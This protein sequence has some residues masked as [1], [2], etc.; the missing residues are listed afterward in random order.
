M[1]LAIM[2]AGMTGAYLYR[3]L[4]QKIPDIDIF[5]LQPRTKCGISPCGWGTSRGFEDLVKT[6]GLDPS[7]YILNRLDHLTMDGIK[8]KAEI[9]TFDKRRLIGD[10]LRGAEV[11]R[12]PPDTGRYDRVIDATGAER[13][14]LPPVPD[15][16]VFTCVQHR[17]RTD[18][19]L[20]NRIS[21]GKIGYA[22]TFPLQPREYHVGCG[23]LLADPRMVLRNLGWES[24]ASSPRDTLCACT[25]R[26]RLTGPHRSGPFISNHKATEV[27]GVGEA[28]GC[29][30]PIAGDGI[31]PG[32]KSALIL[33]DHWDDPAGYE[34]AIL[35][36][37]KWME[38]ERRVMDKLRRNEA[39]ALSDAWA[40]R[41]NSKRMGVKVGLRD[42]AAYLRHL[43]G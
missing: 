4:C 33:V 40:V 21:L 5:D 16:L 10:L 12:F 35:R 28:I 17:I 34:K 42:A 37:F 24:S 27:W 32:M 41:Q 11:K 29:V 30:S 39:L 7:G 13:A 6:S 31:V 8:V 22:W 19:E 43:T 36:E 20:G 9:M 38:A 26:I 15:D 1:N 23:C 18:T 2:G 3:L 14:F 25:G